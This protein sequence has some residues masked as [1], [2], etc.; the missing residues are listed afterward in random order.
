MKLNRKR[1]INEIEDIIGPMLTI[2]KYTD[3]NLIKLHMQVVKH[4]K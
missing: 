4:E 2:K 1:L 3:L